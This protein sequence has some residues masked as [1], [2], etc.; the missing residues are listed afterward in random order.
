MDPML[1]DIDYIF[2]PE[3]EMTF[4][5]PA[6]HTFEGVERYDVELQFNFHTI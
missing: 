4:H 5:S 2:R 6:E 1:N 3:G